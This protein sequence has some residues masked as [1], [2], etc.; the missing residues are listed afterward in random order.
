M[1]ML[2]DNDSGKKELGSEVEMLHIIK[3]PSTIRVFHSRLLPKLFS[4]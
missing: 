3:I 1:A 4:R 2:A